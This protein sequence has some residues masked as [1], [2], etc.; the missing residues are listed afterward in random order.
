ME[1]GERS[2]LPSEV[3]GNYVDEQLPS[4]WRVLIGGG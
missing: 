1:E 2:F 3:D 4:F